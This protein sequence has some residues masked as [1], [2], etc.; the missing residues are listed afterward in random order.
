MATGTNGSIRIWDL[1]KP[2]FPRLDLSGFSPIILQIFG[3]D[4]LLVTVDR[5]RHA[6]LYDLLKQPIKKTILQSNDREDWFYAVAFG[7]DGRLLTGGQDGTIRAWDVENPND[8]G[9]RILKDSA[10]RAASSEF[11]YNDHI[12]TNR[13]DDITIE[14]PECW[15]RKVEPVVL[16]GH[17]EHWIVDH[18]LSPEGRLVSWDAVGTARL[19]DLAVPNAEPLELRTHK[20]GVTGLGFAPDGQLVT[21]SKDGEIR[22]WNLNN[23]GATPLSLSVEHWSTENLAI[24]PDG[25]VAAG[26]GTLRVWDLN[27]PGDEPIVLGGGGGRGLSPPTDF[28]ASGRMGAVDANG[29]LRVWDLKDGEAREHDVS[30]QNADSSGF[31]LVDRSNIVVSD[32]RGSLEP[33]LEPSDPKAIEIL[34]RQG[35]PPTHIP[36]IVDEGRFVVGMGD[37]TVLVWNLADPELQPITL[38]GHKGSVYHLCSRTA[39]SPRV[40]RMKPFGSMTST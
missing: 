37:G 34:R 23:R 19:W 2:D 13:I 18:I 16:R 29:R 5:S 33:A 3:P 20:G 12:I 24:S 32:A 14:V 8:P 36:K 22:V 17:E 6:V 28:R 11:T 39:S 21:S 30:S 1:S 27:K 31:T 10:A 25:H 7:P 9:P 26:V 38:R 15:D 4:G 40:Q 35:L